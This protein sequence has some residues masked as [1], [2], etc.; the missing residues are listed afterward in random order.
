MGLGSF[1]ISIF[2]GTPAEEEEESNGLYTTGVSMR[3]IN[4]AGAEYGSDWD[5]WN[6]Q[7]FFTWPSSGTLASE[8][9]YL[10]SKG[11]NCIRLP[12]AWERLQHTLNGAFN[13]TYQTN[14]MNFVTQA[15]AAGFRVMVDLHNYNRYATGTHTTDQG[16]TQSGGYV[17]R[18]LGDG[19][20]T[21]AHLIDVWTKLATLFVGND[22]VMF[23]LM[24][25]SHDFPVTSTNYFAM[26][27]AQI[28]AIRGTGATQLILA[29]N[30][31]ASDVTHWSSYSPNGGP[32]D[33]V[34][35]LDVVDSGNNYCFDMHAYDTTPSS[36][37]SYVTMVTP[38]TNWARTNGKK[39]FLSELGC[40]EAAPNAAA[41]M[42]NLLT[43]LNANSDVWIGWT[44]W[45]LQPFNLTQNSPQSYVVDDTM[46]NVFEPFLTPNTASNGL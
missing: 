8:L 26:V 20:L 40:D 29:P 30:S 41:A 23:N 14:M 33:S 45:N 19:F 7:T 2:S 9:T 22:M 3:G 16:T 39:L 34:A 38:V 21:N 24:N 37:T 31:R 10:D 4:R 43:Y 28:V 13:T 25:E 12:I 32:L 35:A 1:P 27:N 17:Q 18:I 11:F 36:S 42:T 46:M 44:P 15:N 5:G 6:G